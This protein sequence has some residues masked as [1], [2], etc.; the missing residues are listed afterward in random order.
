MIARATGRTAI[1]IAGG[2]AAVALV[3][4]MALPGSHQL[5][6]PPKK[7]AEKRLQPPVDSLPPSLDCAFN[8]FMHSSTAINFYFDVTMPEGAPPLFLER[9]FVAA[10]GDRQVYEDNDRPV[11][12]YGRDGDNQPTITSPDGATTIVLYGLK[13]GLSGVGKVEAG[14]RSS[15]FRNLGGQCRQTNLDGRKR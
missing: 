13:L 8:A 12:T 2:I 3:G 4:F 11:W 9:A 10:D 15:V 7:T 14:V 1:L 5:P 6:V